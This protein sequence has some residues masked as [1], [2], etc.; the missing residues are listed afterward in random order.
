MRS[1]KCIMKLINAL[2]F[3]ATTPACLRSFIVLSSILSNLASTSSVCCPNV[4]GGLR[5]LGLFSLNFTGGET[6][7]IGPQAGCCTSVTMPRA[8]SCSCSSVSLTSLIAAYGIPEPSKIANHSFVFF[9]CV[10]FSIMDS[11]SFLFSTLTLLVLNLG[12][13]FHSG[14]ESLSHIMPKRRSFPPPIMMSP[15]RV[16]KPLYG[17]IDAWQP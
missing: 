15:S 17:T 9:V 3:Y 7:F 10:T 16:L 11:S 6:S 14:F 2:C 1:V 5:I 12:S 4:G 8:C 13:V